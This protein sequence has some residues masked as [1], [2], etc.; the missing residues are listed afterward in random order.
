MKEKFDGI[1]SCAI[2]GMMAV[3]AVVGGLLVELWNW[4]K[5]LPPKKKPVEEAEEKMP[6]FEFHCHECG[7][8]FMVAGLVLDN[9]F[10]SNILAFSK[11]CPNCG[12]PN[13]NPVVFEDD[14]CFP[15]QKQSWMWI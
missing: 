10:E 4:L 8:H 7:E 2:I 5:D 14:E 6:E 11:K 3:I 1:I 15:Q 9:G 13:I 12:S